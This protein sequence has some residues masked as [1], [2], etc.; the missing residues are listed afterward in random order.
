MG[1]VREWVIRLWVVGLLVTAVWTVFG[2]EIAALL[3]G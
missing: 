2:Q 3:A 1:E